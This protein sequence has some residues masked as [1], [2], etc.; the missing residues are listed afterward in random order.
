MTTPI[1][2][3]LLGIESGK[4]K[5]KTAVRNYWRETFRRVPDLNLSIIEVASGVDSVSIYYHAA[6]GNK[7]IE[8]FFF[9]E[10]GK[11]YKVVA[12]YF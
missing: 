6:L 10:D 3:Q 5:G 11:V 2:T 12:T 7:A 8:T 4:L 9:N 1:V